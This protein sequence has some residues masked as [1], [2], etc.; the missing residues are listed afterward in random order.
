MWNI[1]LNV[2][3]ARGFLTGFRRGFYK[4][5]TFVLEE[6]CLGRDFVKYVFYL[7][8]EIKNFKTF[9]DFMQVTGLLFNIYIM[10]DSKCSIEQWLWD[11][12]HWCFTHNCDP[13]VLLKN[14]MK[15]VFQATGAL[16]AIAAVFYEE[17]PPKDQH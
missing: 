10:F 13:E 4:N 6:Q 9:N 16:N 2:S 17:E 14:E 1:H 15:N 8:F 3:K 11:M 7:D 12:S 5:Y